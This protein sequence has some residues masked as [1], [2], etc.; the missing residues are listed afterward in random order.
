MSSPS[1]VDGSILCRTPCLCSF[2]KHVEVQPMRPQGKAVNRGLNRLEN[3]PENRPL[4]K[5]AVKH[6]TSSW[7]GR[8]TSCVKVGHRLAG[9]ELLIR[10]NAPKVPPLIRRSESDTCH[11]LNLQMSPSTKS[12]AS[13]IKLT[14]VDSRRTQSVLKPSICGGGG[15]GGGVWMRRGELV[16]GSFGSNL[17]GRR[18]HPLL[19]CGD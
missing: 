6:K 10:R 11:L 9:N 3:R 17:P 15:G 19:M 5:N 13:F 1:S 14:G 18:H 2:F 16:S 12:C 4:N 7:G 8:A